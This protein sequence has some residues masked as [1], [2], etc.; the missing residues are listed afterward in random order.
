MFKN[1][2]HA[3]H[4]IGNKDQPGISPIDYSKFKYGDNIIAEKFGNELFDFFLR[5]FLSICIQKKR[6]IVIYS[7]PYSFLPTSSLLMTI[8]FFNRLKHYISSVIK[9][10]CE[11]KI[12]KINRNHSYTSDYGAMSATERFELI[13]NDTYNLGE[14]PGPDDILF[15]LDDISITGTHQLVIEKLLDTHGILNESFFLYYAKLDNAFIDP[16][17]ENEL[18]YAYVKTVETLLPVILSAQFQNT[19]RTT[20]FILSQPE[21]ALQEL[22]EALNNHQKMD[23]L[24]QM[25]SGAVRNK[26]HLEKVYE[27]SFNYFSKVGLFTNSII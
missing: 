21:S 27:H 4:S 24:V 14:L 11:V 6:T 9:I 5:E 12:G 19:T 1:Q 13:Q 23:V 26:Y 18:N 15:F 8:A 22:I 3:V 10:D 25:I 16:S 17:F 7:S 20:K 2:R